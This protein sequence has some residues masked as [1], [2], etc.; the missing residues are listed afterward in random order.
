MST[1]EKE[2]YEMDDEE[3][4]ASRGMMVF[5]S[6]GFALAVAVIIVSLVFELLT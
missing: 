1:E 4:L 5:V 3:Q 2:S 6:S